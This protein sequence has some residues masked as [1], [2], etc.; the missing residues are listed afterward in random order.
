MNAESPFSR[1]RI[2]TPIGPLPTD[3][4]IRQLGQSAYI[5]ARIGWRGLS[6]DEYTNEGPLLVAGTHIKGS[7]IDWASCDHI[8]RFRYEESPEIQLQRDD[9][10]LSKD[11]TLGRIGIVEHLPGTATIN[12]TMM[13]VRPD[14]R[15]FWPRFLYYYLQ[16][17]NFRRFIKEKVS[18]SSVPHIFQRDIVRMLAPEP[19][20]PEQRKIAAILS[21]MDDTIEKTQAVVDQVQVVKRGLMQELLTKGLPGR[22]TRFKQTEMGKIP[23]CWET[24]RLGDIAAIRGGKRMPKGRPFARS[25][26]PYPYIRVCDFKNNSIDPTGLQYVLPEDQAKI[27]RYT[28]SKDDLYISIA[29]TLGIVGT[30]PPALDGAQLTENA[31][32]IV[33]ND[34][35]NAD[36]DFLKIAMQTQHCQNQLARLRGIGGGVPKLALFR[37]EQVRLP[38]PDQREQREIVEVM[39]SIGLYHTTLSSQL[40]AAARL[41]SA[42]MSVL[43]GGE[44]RVSPDF[45]TA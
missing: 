22:H 10:I 34:P 5:K 16:G 25:T 13:L 3:W 36:K 30:V 43:L 17:N 18:G 11:G 2:Q 38:L 39:D 40:D 32:K 27:G 4:R 20:L 37:I 15:V 19:P 8:S 44:L 14:T 12:G 28:I 26:T 41:K 7:R 29:G 33:I 24:I 31:A 1:R 45:D 21:A 23:E 35:K 42:L 6:A 9:I